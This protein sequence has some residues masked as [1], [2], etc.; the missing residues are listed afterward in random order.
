MNKTIRTLQSKASK[1]DIM[2]CFSLYE[3]YLKGQDVDADIIIANE[4]L[5]KCH[6]LLEYREKENEKPI[7]KLKIE[8]LL[9]KDFRKFKSLD[10]TFHPDITVVIGDNG[11]G[12]TTITDALAKI[13]SW[14]N[15]RI[16]IAKKGAKKVSEGDINVE[17]SDYSEITAQMNFFSKNIFSSSLARPIPGFK[18][19]KASDL[20]DFNFISDLYRVVNSA[21]KDNGGEEINLPLFCY[22][23]IDRTLTSSSVLT[24]NDHEI[25]QSS[26]SRFKAFSGALDGPGRFNDFV[27]WFLSIHNYLGPSNENTPEIISLTEEIR[28]FEALNLNSSNPLYSLYKEKKHQLQYIIRNKS[29]VLN[30]RYHTQQQIVK[31]AIISC[32]ASVS[33]IFIERRSGKSE[34]KIINDDVIININQASQGQKTLISLIADLSRRLVLLNPNLENPLNGQGIVIIDEIELHLHPQWQQSIIESLTT[35]FPNIQFIITTHSP[36]ILSTVDKDCIRKIVQNIDGQYDIYKPVFQTKG[37][38]SAEI[39]EF[40]MGTNS[41]PDIAEARK[42]D[43]FG[44]FLQQGKEKDAEDLLLELKLHFEEFEGR[45]HPVILNCL[46]QL[47]IYEMKK[48]INKEKVNHK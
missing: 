12:K 40:I 29:A 25:N 10:I 26:S 42:I 44:L 30:E 17:S 7:S 35:T 16:E 8:K 3:K 6:N 43:Q 34:L 36:Q 38:T 9:L 22:Y 13:F 39:M 21:S 28:A 5:K 23:S 15:A 41:I 2:A 11:S 19:R 48:R 37:V 31:K 33:D 45:D 1:N 18:G 27:T 4:Y 46:N 47:K 14:L 32:V 24:Y 20:E